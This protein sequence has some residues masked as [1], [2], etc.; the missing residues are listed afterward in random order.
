MHIPSMIDDWERHYHYFLRGEI[1]NRNRKI[2]SCL[3]TRQCYHTINLSYVNVM[4]WKYSK[5]RFP[6]S[7]H[8][9]R[10][11]SQG[12]EWPASWLW[13]YGVLRACESST[14]SNYNAWPGFSTPHPK[15]P[16][17]GPTGQLLASLTLLQP[18][19]LRH[20]ALVI[21]LPL[22]VQPGGH[23]LLSLLSF[24]PFASLPDCLHAWIL[25]L[26]MQLWADIS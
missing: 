16:S 20:E 17:V 23:L 12:Q 21:I 18:K 4:M 11:T 25:S 10:A 14:S 3:V 15:A 13:V 6:A 2:V 19:L 26:E 9:L 1:E 8:D 24:Y 7:V 22:T 5:E